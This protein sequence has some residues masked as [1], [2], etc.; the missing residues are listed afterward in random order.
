MRSWLLGLPMLS[1]MLFAL[2]GCDNNPEGPA[3]PTVSNANPPGG[4][5][6]PTPGAMPDAGKGKALGTN[7]PIKA[8]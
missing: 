6:A 7:S 2:A 1:L 5:P 8:D 4:S 3:A